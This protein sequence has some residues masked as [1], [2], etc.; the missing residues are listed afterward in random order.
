MYLIYSY[1]SFLY[2]NFS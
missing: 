1:N 2:L